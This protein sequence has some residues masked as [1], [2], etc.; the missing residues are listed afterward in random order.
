MQVETRLEVD[1]GAPKE[2]DP[3]SAEVNEG[4]APSLLGK[5]SWSRWQEEQPEVP[6]SIPRNT[7]RRAP[8]VSLTKTSDDWS[9][10]GS[11]KW[12]WDSSKDWSSSHKK[13]EEDYKDW[14][15]WDND[16]YDYSNFGRGKWSKSKQY[17]SGSS[18]TEKEETVASSSA[19]AQATANGVMLY[20]VDGVPIVSVGKGTDFE[21]NAAPLLQAILQAHSKQADRP[22][23]PLW[24]LP[25]RKPCGLR[26]MSV[27]IEVSLLSGETVQIEV[28]PT[29][30][31]HQLRQKAQTQLQLGIESLLTASGQ[32]LCDL[33]CV[34]E[35]N[36]KDGDILTAV[37]RR[38]Q[39]ISGR[40]SL[41]SR[42]NLLCSVG[43]GHRKILGLCHL[44]A[45]AFAY[46]R[47]DGSVLTWGHEACGG[48][49][50]RV[51]DQLVD[52]EQILGAR[53]G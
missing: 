46:R 49:S 30:R 48:S 47:S 25:S 5:R 42:Q 16:Y 17:R 38:G 37:C 40:E 3:G 52:V 19:P 51:R 53:P 15:S 7:R 4:S 26:A 12:E 31:V 22:F 35:T 23:T 14:S 2:F 24:P 21:S 27:A 11:K 33:D 28:D 29:H 36:L 45:K 43:R 18:W 41:A 13:N 1:L 6:L 32:T 50:K 10:R 8:S 44:T 39:L 9:W 20:V 34:A